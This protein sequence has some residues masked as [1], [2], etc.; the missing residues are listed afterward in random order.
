MI[1][2]TSEAGG[3]AS[4]NESDKAFL[5]MTQSVSSMRKGQ[6]RKSAGAKKATSVSSH[7]K[8]WSNET[9]TDSPLN[10]KLNSRSV[11]IKSF[12]SLSCELFAGSTGCQYPMPE[13][14]NR[15]ATDN[16]SG[17]TPDN[18]ERV[19]AEYYKRS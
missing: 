13:T 5:R 7:R 6:E 12:Q 18:S 19:A 1:E 15:S 2:R 11:V 8:L 4:R 10:A 16:L 17:P 3:R 14:K 9:K